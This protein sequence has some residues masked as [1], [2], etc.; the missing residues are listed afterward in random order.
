[1]ITIKRKTKKSQPRKEMKYLHI[2]IA[3]HSMRE[4][5]VQAPKRFSS[6]MISRFLKSRIKTR[7]INLVLSLAIIHSQQWMPIR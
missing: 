5:R 2:R 4:A 3:S 1:M 6:L 7:I